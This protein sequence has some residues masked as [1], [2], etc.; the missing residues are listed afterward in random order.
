M[1]RTKGFV[2]GLVILPIV[3]CGSIIATRLIGGKTDTSDQRIAIVDHSGM[4]AE[5][6]LSLAEKRNREDII[7]TISGDQTAPAYIVEMV[8]PDSADLTTQRVALSDRIR[9]GELYA[10]VEI[11]KGILNP[12]Q[13][14]TAA[15]ISYH[16]RNPSVDRI[17]RWME[18][19]INTCLRQE[20]LK[21]AGLPDSVI[22]EALAWLSVEK[23]GLLAFDPETGEVLGARR[24]SRLEALGIPVAVMILMFIVIIFSVMPQMSAVTEEKAQRIAEV[25]LGS[26]TPFHLMLGKVIGGVMIA[27]TVSSVYVIVALLA[28]IFLGFLNVL[29][30]HVIPWFAVY[31][32]AAVFMFGA[33][34]SA[35]GTLCS[36]TKDAQNLIFP[37]LFP[38]TFAMF[39]MIPVA[40]NPLAGYATTLSLIPPL[41]PTLMLIRLATPISIPWWQPWVGLI[42]MVGFTFFIVWLSGRI[43]RVGILMQGKPPTLGQIVRW[44]TKG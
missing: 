25:L 24:S 30:L 13:R 34:A 1:V 3:M 4:V 21:Q 40:Q 35:F 8:A 36:E 2:I 37:A 42:G 32:L 33:Y 10:F 27:L 7:D 39:L 18:G 9:Q 19:S 17:P 44:A 23:L 43:F 29:P 38:V 41:T 15:L 11:H 16:A 28:G 22:D 14:T 20:R 31:M 26:V 6:L 5:R 12:V